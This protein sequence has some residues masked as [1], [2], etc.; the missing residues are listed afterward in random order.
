MRLKGKNM[1][2]IYK[3]SPK[4]EEGGESRSERHKRLTNLL[5]KEI[6]NSEL[7]EKRDSDSIC[8]IKALRAALF[9]ISNRI[10][11]QIEVAE[12]L[13]DVS[14]PAY[15]SR[16]KEKGWA[17]TEVWRVPP[18]AYEWYQKLDKGEIFDAGHEIFGQPPFVAPEGYDW[19][20]DPA[21]PQ[22]YALRKRGYKLINDMH[23]T[24]NPDGYVL[25][26]EITTM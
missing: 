24:E 7:R 6:E 11:D 18:D 23:N 22:Y 17:T 13:G 15:L 20:T 3:Q 26:K 14:T 1:K 2:E 16:L 12:K 25:K 4:I 9:A 19:I 8:V 10:E 21:N 5:I